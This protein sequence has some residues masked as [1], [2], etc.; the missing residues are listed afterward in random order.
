MESL[1][2]SPFALPMG[3]CVAIALAFGLLSRLTRL[4]WPA[5]VV[6]T[7]VFVAAYYLTYNKIP[8]FPPVGSANKIFYVSLAGAVLGVALDTLAKRFAAAATGRAIVALSA[9]LAIA[10]WLGLPRFASA[11]PQFW[12][13][14]AA[15]ALGGALVLFRLAELGRESPDGS[16]LLAVLPA[17]FAPIALFGGSSTS[18]GLC[19][20]MTA[21]FGVL[22]LI[23]L[24]APRALGMT[25]VLGGGGALLAMIDTVVLITKRA[26][27]L[28]LFVLLAVLF[29]GQIGARFLLPQDRVGPRVRAVLTGVLAALPIVAI[30]AILS[31][32]NDS[33]F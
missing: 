18:V 31:L 28:A 30:A 1:L 23:G 14:L 19:L 7:L 27:L 24:F 21:G 10:V 16:F 33:P 8:P 17:A 9:A 26:D 4:A 6:A 15:L 20:G 13:L 11:A 3:A 2:D 12:L 32:R 25:A 29:A 5:G 22:A